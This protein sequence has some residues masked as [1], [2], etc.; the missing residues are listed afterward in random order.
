[1]T[2]K[3]LQHVAVAVVIG[4]VVPCLVVAQEG[5]GAGTVHSGRF[6]MVCFR[7]EMGGSGGLWDF[8]AGFV[9]DRLTGGAGG[10]RSTAAGRGRDFDPWGLVRESSTVFENRGTIDPDGNS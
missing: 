6:T 8:L 7:E 2:Q 5:R 4:I 10:G 1:M 9:W 3:I